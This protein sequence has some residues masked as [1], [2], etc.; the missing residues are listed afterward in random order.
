[1]IAL[2]QRS[3]ASAGEDH[4]GQALVFLLD[5]LELLEKRLTHIEQTFA[6]FV[7]T[8]KGKVEADSDQ[9]LPVARQ[10]EVLD[11]IP[12]M[13]LIAASTLVLGSR[14]IARFY[15]GKA[16]SA[17]W[18][19][20]PER[21]QTGT[22]LNKT[23]LTARGDHKRRAMLYLNAQTACIFDPAFAFHKWRM[24]QKGLRPQQAVCAVMNRMA[25][26]SW[27]LVAQNKL[28]DVNHMLEQIK[29]HHADLWKT[30]L[31]LHQDDQFLWKNVEPKFK[32]IS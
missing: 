21:V 17:Q 30:F 14:G 25:R 24:I 29:I 27:T 6:N 22:S 4:D 13:G 2:A 32:K 10:I 1:L 16:L 31:R 20:C 3:I 7:D 18:A 19:S 28:Y 26:L 9:G 23:R 12:G 5:E 15:A 11:S 8:Q